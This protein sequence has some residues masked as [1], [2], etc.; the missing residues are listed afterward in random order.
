MADRSLRWHVSGL[1]SEH[2][3]GVTAIGGAHFLDRDYTPTR[4]FLR[5]ESVASGRP[6]IVDINDDG[7]TIFG[8][9]DKPALPDDTQEHVF[10]AFSGIII[11]KDSTITL[12]IDQISRET[13]GEGLTV[14]LDLDEV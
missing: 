3:G 13:P 9:G 14:Q 1:L 12:D 10:S 7:A 5:L 11:R 2:G 4:V 6:L 8:S